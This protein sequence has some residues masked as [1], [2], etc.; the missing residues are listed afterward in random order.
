[1][2][3]VIVLFLGMTVILPAV[4]LGGRLNSEVIEAMGKGEEAKIVLK[5][6][7]DAGGPVSNASVKF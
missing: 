1:M 7:D 3:R 4:A 5:V 6:C 2:K